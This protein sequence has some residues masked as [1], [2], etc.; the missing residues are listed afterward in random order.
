[1][2]PIAK[3]IITITILTLLSVGC[4]ML[5]MKAARMDAVYNKTMG[6]GDE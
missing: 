2:K 3:T 1:M 4:V 5:S 6:V